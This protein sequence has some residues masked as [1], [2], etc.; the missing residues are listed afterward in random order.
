MGGLGLSQGIPS[1]GSIT[2]PMSRWTLPPAP[3]RL[4]KLKWLKLGCG[5]RVPP[6][7]L[8]KPL[9]RSPVPASPC[10]RCR[11]TP[12]HPAPKTCA[13]VLPRAHGPGQRLRQSRP[14]SHMPP[15]PAAWA[16]SMAPA[17]C[18]HRAQQP[19]M[20]PLWHRLGPAA[21]APGLALACATWQHCP[22]PHCQATGNGFSADT[23]HGD[24]QHSGH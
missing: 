14:C 18:E 11:L 10:S 13:P 20:T 17:C 19:G 15:P 3:S 6:A 5:D 24:P 4:P 2:N 8:A 1:L 7:V 9:P 16:A 22:G 12:A 21:P 23:G